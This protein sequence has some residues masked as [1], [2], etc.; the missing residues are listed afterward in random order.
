MSTEPD[1]E[2]PAADAEPRLIVTEAVLVSGAVL[3]TV[4]GELDIATT[5]TL[6]RRM[7]EIRAA[8]PDRRLHLDMSGL[9]FCDIAGLRSLHAL[10]QADAEGRRQLRITAAGQCLD[11]LLELSDA[12]AVLGYAPPPNHRGDSA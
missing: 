3:I 4:T 8:W 12:A 10:D 5:P 9:L 7:S 2:E 11:V 6:R 1:A